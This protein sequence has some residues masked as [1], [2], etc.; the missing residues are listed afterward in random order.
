MYVQ[1]KQH[2]DNGVKHKQALESYHKEKREK[3]LHGAR[4]EHELK[5]QLRD[6]EKAAKDA[7][8]VDRNEFDGQF[9]SSSQRTSRPPPPPP[10]TSNREGSNDFNAQYTPS[11]TG[12]GSE[13]REDT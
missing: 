1:S 9:Y 13:L 4:S 7:I 3:T 2:H 5:Q 11:D 12:I 8:A 10:I 6:I